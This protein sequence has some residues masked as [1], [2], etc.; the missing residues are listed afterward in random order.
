MLA[1]SLRFDSSVGSCPPGALHEGDAGVPSVALQDMAGPALDN[2][3]ESL[4]A[5]GNRNR[6]FFHGGGNPP[7]IEVALS[8]GVRVFDASVGGLGGCP[9]APGA[10]G[11]VSSEAV[12]AL[13]RGL[14]YETGLDTEKLARAGQMARAMRKG[15]V[16]GHA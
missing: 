12:D 16:D 9:Y 14:G 8:H 10:P 7:N 5:L 1:S 11:N 4:L 3:S 6:T 2:A 15:A 13:V